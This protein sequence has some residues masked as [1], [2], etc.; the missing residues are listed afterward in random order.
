MNYYDK[1]FAPFQRLHSRS[2]FEGTGIGLATVERIIAKHGGRVWAEA[3]PDE[4]AC[5]YFQLPNK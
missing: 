5:F 1:L 4:G 2:D 3:K